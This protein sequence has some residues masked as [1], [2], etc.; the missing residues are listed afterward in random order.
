MYSSIFN[1]KS[2]SIVQPGHYL[3]WYP[4]SLDNEFDWAQRL[5]SK[6]EQRNR[7]NVKLFRKFRKTA[8]IIEK[9]IG[10]YSKCDQSK[11]K[12][13]QRHLQKDLRKS[14][15]S[16]HNLIK[17]FALIN[18][19]VKQIYGFSLHHEQLFCA[20]IL[21]H[22]QLAEMA[23]GEGK[24]ITAALTASVA[25]LAGAPVHVITTNDY[26]VE[27]DATSMQPLFERFGLTCSFVS[28]NLEED[29][30]RQAYSQSICYVSNKQLVFDYLR[31]RQ[32]LGNRPS[33]ISTRVQELCQ[34]QPPKPLLRGLCFA[35]VDEADSVLIDDAITP[36]ILSQQLQGDSE[37]SQSL[38]AISLAR[39]L[40]KEDHFKVDNRNKRVI[41]SEPGENHLADISSGLDGVW[42]NRRFRHELVRQALSAIYL[43]ERDR[44]YIV[45]DGEV[46]LIDQ[47]T[48]RVMP[49][50]K[51]QHGLHQMLETKEKCELTG[52]SETIASLS[53][54]NFFKRYKHLCGMTGTA[55]EAKAELKRVYNLAVV[56]VPTHQKS[57]RTKQLPLFAVD[58]IE[59][60]KLLIA[61][62]E[63]CNS[64]GQP[65]L[66]GTRSL[67]QSERISDSLSAI[68]MQHQVLNARQDKDEAEVVAKA[69]SKRAITIA[70][71][72]AGRGTDIPIEK[73]VHELGGLHVIIA[74]LNDNQRID[75]QLIGRGAR[76]GDPGS[77]KYIT[78]LTDELLV[79]YLP[80][81]ML[82]LL[83][84]NFLRNTSI[85]L[86]VCKSVSSFVQ[87]MHEH[88]QRNIRK[89][90]A[91]NDKEMNKKLSFSGYKE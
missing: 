71:N 83:K 6:I 61:E 45:R 17:A 3:D 81:W 39:R 56:C 9:K 86:L 67:A 51:L 87:I 8:Q 35:I 20:W 59:H 7:T 75:R 33:S 2:A 26:L 80:E 63:K 52:Q 69:G 49:D 40:E 34:M 89:H 28:A 50:R 53:F 79:R 88:Q 46:L 4:E 60:Q 76:Q 12:E 30:R 55:Q 43:F 74:E 66:V 70:T 85:G 41:I 78:S 68:N 14:G 31:D 29:E 42:K 22:G 27:R 54:Q 36:L 32:Q 72:I 19:E 18:V 15:F 77:F 62:I 24:S 91:L 58:E 23:T 84:N 47:S 16:K 21:L 64:V 65:V 13:L 44:D 10:E 90:V 57:R 82:Y 48:G 5:F 37:I 25:A 38:T 11:R 73:E 1:Q